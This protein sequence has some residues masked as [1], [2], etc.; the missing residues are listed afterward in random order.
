MGVSDS[1]TELYAAI[2]THLLAYTDGGAAP[3]TI[4]AAVGTR[5]YNEAPPDPV[6]GVALTVPYLILTIDGSP[7]LDG[8]D[9]TRIEF[10]VEVQV[11]NRPRTTI[12]A[13]RRIA[14]LAWKA[15][16]TYKVATSTDGFVKIRVPSFPETFPPG[17]GD[18][19]REVVQIR[20]VGE[21]YGYWKALSAAL[22]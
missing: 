20:I 9:P 18:A 17:S 3:N 5:I 21:G 10:Q 6:A 1:M 7:A 13:T 19:D 12:A 16:A 11:V 15:L 4:A 2:R 22:T 14:D 8:S